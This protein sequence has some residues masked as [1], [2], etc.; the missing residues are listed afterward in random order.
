MRKKGKEGSKVGKKGVKAGYGAD[1][2]ETEPGKQI[3][4]YR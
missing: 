3:N 1:R 2:Q 4:R